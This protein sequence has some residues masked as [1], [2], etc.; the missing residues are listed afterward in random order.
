MSRMA[1]NIVIQICYPLVLSRLA[2]SI[3]MSLIIIRVHRVVIVKS[4]MIYHTNSSIRRS[5]RIVGSVPWNDLLFVVFRL[6]NPTVSRHV[7]H[8]YILLESSAILSLLN[9]VASTVI[10]LSWR[11]KHISY[12]DL[13]NGDKEENKG[14]NHEDY[15]DD[16]GQNWRRFHVL[17][18][19]LLVFD[20]LILLVTLRFIVRPSVIIL[21][22]LLILVLFATIERFIWILVQIVVLVVDKRNGE[23]IESKWMIE[24][25]FCIKGVRNLIRDL[26]DHFILIFGWIKLFDRIKNK[27]SL[28]GRSIVNL[29]F[30]VGDWVNFDGNWTPIFP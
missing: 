13:K 9:V 7:A 27:L 8:S 25:Q 3:C 14:Q 23:W 17:S 28:F 30:K 16:I 18:L 21:K 24:H 5:V 1:T 20:P 12:V 4:T 29:D 2:T 10:I 19:N 11:E 26:H 6:P 22:N 15:Y